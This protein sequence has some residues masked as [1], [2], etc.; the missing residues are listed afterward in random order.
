MNKKISIATP[1]SSMQQWAWQR[2]LSALLLALTPIWGQASALDATTARLIQQWLQSGQYQRALATI[3]EKLS[4][5]PDDAE[6]LLAKGVV[7]VELGKREEAKQI[8]LRL[9]NEHPGLPEPHNNLA[10]IYAAQG[11]YDKARATLEA[12]IKTHPSYATAFENLGDL[13]AKLA[14]QSYAKAL[15]LARAQKRDIQPKLRLLN[16]VIALATPTAVENGAGGAIGT[17]KSAR[18]SNAPAQDESATSATVKTTADT[19]AANA[20]TAP[21]A[22]NGVRHDIQ[23]AVESWADAWSKRDI[24]RYLDHYAPDFATPG[25]S[26]REWINDRTQKIVSKKF[27][28]VKISNISIRPIDAGTY[29]VRF[30]QRYRSDQLTA[31]TRKTLVFANKN[32]RWLITSE[33]SS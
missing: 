12:A 9:V 21:G 18:A 23:A 13:Y 4:K 27:I 31:T 19:T 11:E 24:Q 26:N 29:Q 5:A 8:F 17:V 3:D 7:L 6:L 25:M 22:T 10:V 33:R 16:Q 30:V 20:R 1:I 14:S 15:N 32:G 28:D 2:G